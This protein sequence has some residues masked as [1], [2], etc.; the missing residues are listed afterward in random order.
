MIFRRL[1]FASMLAAAAPAAL[2]RG[3]AAHGKRPEGM[4]GIVRVRAN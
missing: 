3:E 4:V 1:M 2:A